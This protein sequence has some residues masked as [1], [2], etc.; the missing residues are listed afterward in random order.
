[1]HKI[2]TGDFVLAPDGQQG[3][4]VPG[5]V[6]DGFEKRASCDR[7]KLDFNIKREARFVRSQNSLFPLQK[8][9]WF[10]KVYLL[11]IKHFCSHLTIK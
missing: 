11:F 9:I 1:M 7:K 10:A 3:R 2:H 6:L 5:E 4:F 8:F